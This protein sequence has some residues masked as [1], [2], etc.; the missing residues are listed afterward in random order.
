MPRLKNVVHHFVIA[1][2]MALVNIVRRLV[3]KI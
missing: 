3:V 1:V 2:T